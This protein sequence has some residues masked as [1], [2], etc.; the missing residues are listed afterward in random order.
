MATDPRRDGSLP[1]RWAVI[2]IASLGS[3]LAVVNVV[4]L[5]SGITVGVALAG[6]LHKILPRVE[7]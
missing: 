5:V 1:I 6:L 3:A 2:I 4:D 7:G